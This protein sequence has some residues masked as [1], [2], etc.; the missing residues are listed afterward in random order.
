[1]AHEHRL[2]ERLSVLAGGEAIEAVCSDDEL[3]RETLLDTLA[4]LV[5]KCMSW[6]TLDR[7]CAIGCW[8]RYVSTRASTCRRMLVRPRS[9]P[10]TPYAEQRA[11]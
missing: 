4:R 1:V 6:P 5:D 8:K 9:V 11:L 10:G 3:S 7:P 2:F